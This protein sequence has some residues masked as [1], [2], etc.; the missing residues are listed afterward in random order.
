MQRAIVRHRGR[1]AG[2]A[3]VVREG[4]Q[5]A[6]GPAPAH[7]HPVRP[8]D[9][10]GGRLLQRHR[11]L[12]AATST[13]AA[14]ASRPTP[15]ST[16]SPRTSCSSSTRPTSP[17]R[18]STASTRATAPARRRWSTTASACRRR[19]DNRPL[20]F[21]EV[22]R[23]GQPGGL[24][25][26]HAGRLRARAV[27]PGGRADRA[28]HRP[29]RPRGDRQAHQGP[30]RRPHGADQR[31]GRPRATASSSPPSPRR[32]P[33]T[34]PTTCSSWAC[35]CATCTARST[36]SSA[37]RSCAT[38]GSASSTC[39]SA[40]TCCGRASTCPRCRWWPSSTP[41]RRAS[42]AARRR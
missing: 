20:R 25:V 10:A 8:G 22:V 39:W 42:S 6:R 4:G 15:C 18:S 17:C 32:W 29:D 16:T 33:R 9:D 7:A 3:G 27:D 37:S 35:G 26:G 34:S 23:A 13:A 38:C 14:P 19:A 2:A 21:D 24:P 5:A 41:T 12:L 31:P 11:E 28:A 36:P 1:A 30:D 40:S